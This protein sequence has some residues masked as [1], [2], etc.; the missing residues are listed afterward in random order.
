MPEKPSAATL[1]NKP[2]KKELPLYSV[3][4]LPR[5]YGHDGPKPTEHLIGARNA[6]AALTETRKR[7]T[8]AIAK[9]LSVKRMR[10]YPAVAYVIVRTRYEY[11]AGDQERAAKHLE[12]AVREEI[13]NSAFTW[14]IEKLL[15]TSTPPEK[16]RKGRTQ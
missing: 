15:V 1:K 8:D 4:Y 11:L 12:D 6:K 3:L 5:Y 9:V 14:E 16:K 13:R 2:K 10:R 7:L